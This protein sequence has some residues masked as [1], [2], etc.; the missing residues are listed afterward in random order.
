M[1]RLLLFSVFFLLIFPGCGTDTDT[2][3][4]QRLT[5]DFFESPQGWT[6]EF[7]DLPPDDNENFELEVDFRPLPE[8]LDTT[9]NALFISGVNLS[10]DLFMYFKQQFTGLSPDQEVKIRYQIRF[11]TNVPQNCVGAGGVPG[12]SVFLKAGTSIIEPEPVLEMEGDH[13]ILRLSVDKG[14]QSQG[15]ENAVV[16]GN[17]ANSKDCSD[18]NAE[19]WELKDLEMTEENAI[20]V[21]ADENG[22]V[23]FF[24]G[25][26]SGFEGRTSLFYSRVNVFIESI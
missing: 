15:G 12:E 23:W 4:T 26:D 5:F 1:L 9:Q 10:D 8:P 24:F 2:T 11:A 13:E 21:T 17:I 16:L 18:E 3:F 20:E 7:A 6:G 22:R 14:N 25:T 19:E